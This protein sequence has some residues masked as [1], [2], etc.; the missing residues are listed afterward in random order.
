[1]PTVTA[2][3]QL[4]WKL[5]FRGTLLGLFMRLS[6]AHEAFHQAIFL[7]ANQLEGCEVAAII[8]WFF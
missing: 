7:R 2:A 3:F 5:N 4:K 8:P 6:F 1:M